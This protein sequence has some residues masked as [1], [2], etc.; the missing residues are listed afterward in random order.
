M[1]GDYTT[2]TAG[3]S[4]SIESF[5]A[6]AVSTQV[7]QTQPGTCKNGHHPY[8]REH[9]FISSHTEP[10]HSTFL[11]ERTNRPLGGRRHSNPD[12]N[13][14]QPVLRG[15][16]E[17]LQLNADQVYDRVCAAGK[18]LRRHQLLGCFFSDDRCIDTTLRIKK[19]GTATVGGFLSNK[20]T[21]EVAAGPNA[22][23][24]VLTPC[25][26]PPPPRATASTNSASATRLVSDAADR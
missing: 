25:L 11:C 14:P 18:Q 19:S 20:I 5:G 22:S 26:Q 15:R 21:N 3:G 7:R 1:P 13:R 12:G 17:P 8:S 2:A 24:F 6:I 16:G 23:D 4:T 9:A 10:D